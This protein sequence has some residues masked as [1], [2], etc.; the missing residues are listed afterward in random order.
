MGR[1][2][3]KLS[4]LYAVAYKAQT[5]IVAFALGPNLEKG[6]LHRLPLRHHFFRP[7]SLRRLV[8]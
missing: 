5:S 7:F 2:T 1:R 8:Q 4:Q 6:E 3:T